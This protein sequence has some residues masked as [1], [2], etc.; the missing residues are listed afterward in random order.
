MK[1][2]WPRAGRQAALWGVFAPVPVEGKPEGDRSAAAE[3]EAERGVAQRQQQQ[4]EEAKN[5]AE[6]RD[7]EFRRNDE[8]FIV[9]VAQDDNDAG[10][11]LDIAANDDNDLDR[12]LPFDGP[13]ASAGVSGDADESGEAGLAWCSS[14]GRLHV[15]ALAPSSTLATSFGG[16]HAPLPL[17]EPRLAEGAW[18]EQVLWDDADAH[19]LPPASLVLDPNDPHMLFAHEAL[20]SSRTRPSDPAFRDAGGDSDSEEKEDQKEEGVEQVGM[21]GGIHTCVYTLKPHHALSIWESITYFDWRSFGF[22]SPVHHPISLFS[23]FL[24]FIM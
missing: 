17:R 3:S 1:T 18:L 6:L 13:S 14:R 21:G 9:R 8:L 11:D 5:R 20:T 23:S 4:E 16:V 12:T 2:T 15:D 24:F 10:V 22:F 7:A 19:L